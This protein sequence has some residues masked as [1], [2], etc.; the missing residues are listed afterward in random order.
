MKF[1]RVC[2]LLLLLFVMTGCISNVNKR[3][4]SV[5]KEEWCDKDEDMPWTGCWRE[6]CRIECET[7]EDFESD[8]S[9]G[10]LRL[11]SDGHFSVTW[12]PFESYTD[13]VGSY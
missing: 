6:V 1:L 3:E 12:H 11:K 7:G 13:Y 9:I 2:V 5:S 10:E 4:G 8:E